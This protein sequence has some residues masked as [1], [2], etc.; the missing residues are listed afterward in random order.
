MA[1]ALSF[2]LPQAMAQKRKKH[3]A[4][5]LV[6]TAVYKPTPPLPDVITGATRA[7]A[8]VPIRYDV[9][10]P[11]AGTT[12]QWSVTGGGSVAAAVGDY[13]FI[14]F[15]TLPATIKA[16][17]VTTDGLGCVSD[18]LYYDVEV[19]VPPMTISGA[20]TV[21]HSTIG[22]YAL[23]YMEADHYEW[24]LS[25]PLLGSVIHGETTPNPQV[26][27]NMPAPPGEDVWL[28]AKVTK[29]GVMVT[30]SFKVYIMGLPVI[31]AIA[32]LPNDTICSDI[33]ITLDVTTSVPI[34]SGTFIVNWGDGPAMTYA[35]PA[36][37]THVYT[38][39][40]ISVNMTFTPVVTLIDANECLGSVTANAP[41]ITVKPAPVAVVSPGGNIS[42]CGVFSAETLVATV[43]TGIGG[44]ETYDWNTPTVGSDPGNVPVNNLANA[45][46]NYSVTVTNSISGCSSTSNMVTIVEN[47]S[48]GSSSG[49][50]CG[51]GP[52]V[53]L[54]ADTAHCGAISVTAT[55]G[56]GSWGYEW[57]LPTGVTLTGTPSAT[58]LTASTTVA[59]VYTIRYKVFFDSLGCYKIHHINV[60]VPYIPDLRYAISCNQVG[61]NYK[62][63]LFDH[64][65]EY[66]LT[67]I[68]ARTYYQAG[69]AITGFGTNPLSV[70]VYQAAGDTVT[71]VQEISRPGFAP[72]YDTI[73]VSTPAFPAVSV[74]MDTSNVYMPGC[75]KD[76]AFQITHIET[77]TITSHL[78]TFGDLSLNASDISPIGKV[79]DAPSS[80]LYF[81]TLRVTD[82]YGCYAEGSVSI[83]V[84]ADPY[85]AQL[86]VIGSPA[87]QGDPVTLQYNNLGTGSPGTYTWYQE[88]TPLFT[89]AATTYNVFQPG[90]YW[91]LGTDGNGCRVQSDMKPVVIHQVPPVS[92]MGNTGACIDQ[93]FT[94]TTQ[95]YGAG[96]TYLWSGAAAGAG[97]S[98]PQTI[99][100]PGAYTYYVTITH[101]AT[102][103]S[104]ISPA[105]TVTISP[106]PAAPTLSFN[107]MDCDPYQVELTAVGAPGTYNWSNG[108]SGTPIYTPFGG[109]YQVTLTDT[110]GCVVQ[111]SI[112]V[113][114]SLEEYIWIFP[115]G[116]FCRQQEAYVIG[117]IL[118]L[119]WGWMKDGSFDVAGSGYMPPYWL[120]PGHT[121][122]MYLSNAWCDLTSDD[123]YYMSDTCDNLPGGGINRNKPYDDKPSDRKQESRLEVS[124]NPADHYA[125][126][127]FS[128][129]AGSQA[130]S[131]EL[132][133][134]T[135]RVLQ[136]HPLAVET[137]SIRLSL[138]GY[139]SGMYHVVLRRDGAV[140]Q[141]VKLSVTQ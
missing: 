138:G 12:F 95:D 84:K 53:S 62:I 99:A 103:C 72:C 43:T 28:I 122:N 34:T 85:T 86:D 39:T 61:S 60:L 94:L 83:E 59:G 100:T 120:T 107:I 87:C 121:Y 101:T 82:L 88:S 131:I 6:D 96:Y 48:G 56:A 124:P 112:T 110:N 38:T 76:V 134:M 132:V 71:Y 54:L 133:D 32:V 57:L 68:T 37:L 7:C 11:V 139:A 104:Q 51:A 24:A 127:H 67:G 113:P 3:S 115:T 75:E 70:D 25:N 98:L 81:P 23:S 92:I 89:G 55:V 97:T 9:G 141:T 14:T 140:A 102:G 116:C 18:T 8:G 50:S 42:H 125:M 114:K 52:S 16:V 74:F 44:S 80:P 22:S 119:G 5:Q 136:Q 106:P 123:M 78:W 40:G 13:S 4:R 128:V 17:R 65:T 15:G 1:I 109:D 21:C 137:G 29:C 26:Q 64:S 33:P 58:S 90:G 111:N 63:T 69:T 41:T 2:L 135:G 46:G 79:Y 49:D 31:T 93:L 117:P 27:W 20:D 66:P 35:Y 73:V 19:A 36:A 47:C 45:Y 105:F 126:A 77:G 130:R 91:V 10:N 108:S 118:P 30:K 129:A